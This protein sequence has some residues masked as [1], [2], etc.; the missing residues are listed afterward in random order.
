MVADLQQ[1]Q[2]PDIRHYTTP[3]LKYAAPYPPDEDKRIVDLLDEIRAHDRVEYPAAKA[4]HVIGHQP[5]S[6]SA[7]RKSRGVSCPPT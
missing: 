6:C 2:H 3:R 5:I 4:G 1:R 7:N